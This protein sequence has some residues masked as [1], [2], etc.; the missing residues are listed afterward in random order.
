MPT[1]SSGLLTKPRVSLSREEVCSGVENK[2]GNKN[3]R[4]GSKWLLCVNDRNRLVSN[5]TLNV[6]VEG[7][8]KKEQRN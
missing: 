1:M 7:S 5:A 4:L 2:D 6:A 8:L 3:V